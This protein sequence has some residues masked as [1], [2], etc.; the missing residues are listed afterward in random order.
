M[1][2][3]STNTFIAHRWDGSNDY[4]KIANAVERAGLKPS[5]RSISEDAPLDSKG[6]HLMHDIYNK[7][8]SAST[9]FVPA[10]PSATKE[11]TVS[12]KEIEHAMEQG[13]TIIAVDTG[14]TKRH[15]S[16]FSKNDIPVVPARK[17]SIAKAVR[18]SEN[19]K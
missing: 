4:D 5:D 3:K 18:E 7:I 13:K 12:R 8:D 11:G 2:K 1:S 15:S 17:D 9:V 19:V 14:A 10:R 16:F 6:N